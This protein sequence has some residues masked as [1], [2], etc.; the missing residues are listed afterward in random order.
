[1][2]M[3]MLLTTYLLRL[4]PAIIG[5]LG[6]IFNF[7]VLFFIGGMI[8]F[9]LHILFFFRQTL[10]PISFIILIYVGAFLISQHFN[11]IIWG[12]LISTCFEM[13]YHGIK[14]YFALNKLKRPAI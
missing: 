7:S 11:G 8:C 13:L 4:S 14:T 6:V 1:M 10:R 3:K 5:L 12:A 9:V 2:I